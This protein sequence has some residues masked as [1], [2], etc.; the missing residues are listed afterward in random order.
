MNHTNLKKKKKIP[1]PK[2]VKLKIK[3]VTC[4]RCFGLNNHPKDLVSLLSEEKKL[5]AYE[6]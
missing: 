2:L 4:G 3:I 6:A 1:V 5:E